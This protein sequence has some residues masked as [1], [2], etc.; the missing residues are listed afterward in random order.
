MSLINSPCH[1]QWWP[2]Q[3]FPTF[4][5]LQHFHLSSLWDCHSPHLSHFI[6]K[7]N[8]IRL[9]NS[10]S[11][12]EPSPQICLRIWSDFLPSPEE[13]SLLLCKAVP[14]SYVCFVNFF[15]AILMR[16]YSLTLALHLCPSLPPFPRSFT[17]PDKAYN[18]LFSKCI[19]W[20]HIPL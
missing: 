8:I 20:P 11:L 19:P 3:S 7:T 4:S 2:F 5:N 6:N 17:M 16:K 9:K 14:S 15:S 1:C 18:I 13:V 10:C 12:L